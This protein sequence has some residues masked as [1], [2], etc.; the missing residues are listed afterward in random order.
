MRDKITKKTNKLKFIKKTKKIKFTKNKN[1]IIDV[2]FSK[3]ISKGSLASLGN[4]NYNYLEFSNTF[5]YFKILLNYNKHFRKLVCIPNIS[6]SWM[7]AFLLIEFVNNDDIKSIRPVDNNININEFIKKIKSCIK[8]HRI[9]PVNF[10]L[11]TPEYGKHANMIIFDSEKKTIEHFEPHG[12]HEDSQWSISRAYIKSIT[13]VKKFA[14]KYFPNY[15]IISPKDYEPRNGL[16]SKID[17]YSGMCVTWSIL[18][19]NY[20][21]LNPNIPVK[22]LVRHIN[23][24]ITRNKLLRFTRYVER[25]LKKYS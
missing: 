1:Q 19:L 16:Q 3:E 14:K 21:I 11:E 6:Q 22:K 8:T 17:A 18:Y 23:K 20:R 24:T 9:I 7:K 25:I 4:I 12:Y 2:P 15:R 13:G 5:G 10:S